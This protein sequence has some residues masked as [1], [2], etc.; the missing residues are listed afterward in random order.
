MAAA[1]E[2]AVKF[3]VKCG[4][5]EAKREQVGKGG[6][7]RDPEVHREVLETVIAAM[8]AMGLAPWGLT[9][10]PIKGVGGNT[11]FLLHLIKTDAVNP[12]FDAQASIDALIGIV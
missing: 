10:S 9:V 11:E 8:P 12:D 3:Y 4:F 2:S 7:V 5:V 6:I 1:N